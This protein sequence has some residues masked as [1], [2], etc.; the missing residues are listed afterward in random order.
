MSDK[1]ILLSGEFDGALAISMLEKARDMGWGYDALAWTPQLCAF[2]ELLIRSL[3][4]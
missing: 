1:L 4:A 2:G 3:C